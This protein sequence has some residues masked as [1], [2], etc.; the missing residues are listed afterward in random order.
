MLAMMLALVSMCV[1]F[2]SCGDDDDDAVPAAKEVVGTYVSN[3]EMTVMGETSTTENA[4]VKIEL[5][6]EATAKITLPAAGGGMM[7]LPA[8]EVPVVKVYNSNGTC[9]LSLPQEKYTGTVMGKNN[10]TGEDEEKTYTVQLSGTFVNS[11]LTLN[12]TLQ[13]GS[14]PAAMVGKY[15]ATKK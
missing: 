11:T 5:V 12:Y 3:L 2:T 8:L 14:M 15:V 13:Y 1:A 4:T 7:A 10:K 9:T 6:D